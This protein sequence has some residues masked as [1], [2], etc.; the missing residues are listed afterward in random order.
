M[1]IKESGCADFNRDEFQD[2]YLEYVDHE[3]KHQQTYSKNFRKFLNL[4]IFERFS[5]FEKLIYES[6]EVLA[7]KEIK[8]LWILLH[9]M[10]NKLLSTELFIPRFADAHTRKRLSQ[11]LAKLL[12][13]FFQLF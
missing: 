1:K 3:K 9:I 8:I 7:E 10:Q 13:S 11:S 6:P 2:Y 4:L 12:L 5:E